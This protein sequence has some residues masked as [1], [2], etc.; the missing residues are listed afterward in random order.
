M[1]EWLTTRQAVQHTGKSPSAIRR[2]IARHKI[3]TKK[4]GKVANS[5]VLISKGH[6]L[7][8]CAKAESASNGMPPDTPKVILPAHPPV[9][10]ADNK[11]LEHLEKT[12]EEYKR[13]LEQARRE[14]AELRGELKALNEENKALLRSQRGNRGVFGYLIDKVWRDQK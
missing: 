10:P 3:P 8:A 9:H 5:P 6:L 12:L 2:L 11:Y 13:Q 1:I 4:Q 7:V 14:I